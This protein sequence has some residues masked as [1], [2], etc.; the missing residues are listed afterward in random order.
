MPPPPL[1]LPLRTCVCLTLHFYTIV[2]CYIQDVAGGHIA[3]MLSCPLSVC[4]AL[5]ST[6]LEICGEM[7]IMEIVL[8]FVYSVNVVLCVSSENASCHE[9]LVLVMLTMFE[10]YSTSTD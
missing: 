9:I 2:I 10:G 7:T 1:D 5:I 8:N 6:G 4:M 3:C